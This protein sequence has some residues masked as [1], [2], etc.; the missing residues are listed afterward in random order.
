MQRSTKSVL[1]SRENTIHHH[2]QSV[3]YDTS[4]YEKVTHNLNNHKCNEFQS[5]DE[6]EMFSKSFNFLTKSLLTNNT[7]MK[8]AERVDITMKLKSQYTT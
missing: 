8:L 3:K 7:T 2:T 6:N 4:R 5:P 1:N